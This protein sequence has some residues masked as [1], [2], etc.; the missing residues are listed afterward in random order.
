MKRETGSTPPVLLLLLPLLL[1]LPPGCGSGDGGDARTTGGCPPVPGNTAAE[2][3]EWAGLEAGRA[4][5]STATTYFRSAAEKL[6]DGD[7][8]NDGAAAPGDLQR[9]EYGEVLCLATVPLGIVDEFLSGLLQPPAGGEAGALA[10]RLLRGGVPFLHGLAARSLPPPPGRGAATAGDAVPVSL[11]TDYM[12]EMILPPIDRS[13]ERLEDV[14]SSPSFACELPVM[15]LDFLGAS[16]R[17]PAASPTGTGEHDLGEAYL[18]KA[19]L[20]F[21]RFLCRTVLST[22]L[23]LDAERIDDILDLILGGDPRELIELLDRYPSLLTVNTLQDSGV[24]GR[25]ALRQAKADLI[26]AVELLFDDDD[27][28]GRYWLDHRGTPLDPADDR[29]DPDERPD[30]FFDAVAC[31][32]DG[33]GDDIVRWLDRSTRYALGINAAA[34]GEPLESPLAGLAIRALFGALDAGVMDPVTRALYGTWPP[35]PDAA[36]GSPNGVDDDGD[37]EPDDGPA[38]AT[39]L[40]ALLAGGDTPL[41]QGARVGLLLNAL[42]DNPVDTRDLLPVWDLGAGDPDRLWF[43]VD[44]TESFEDTNGNGRYDPGTDALHD[45]PHRYGPYHF[46]PDGEYEP[47][48][49][50]FRHPTFAGAL[51]FGGSLAGADPHDSANRVLGAVLDRLL[52]SLTRAGA[53]EAGAARGSGPGAAAACVPREP[54]FPRSS[55]PEHLTVLD[56]YD[57]PADMRLTL[58]TLQGVVNRTAPRIY[59]LLSALDHDPAFDHEEDWLAHMQAAYGVTAGTAASPGELLDRFGGELAGVVVYDPAL[60]GSV[61]VA[62][63]LAGLERAAVIHPDRIPEMAARG[64]PVLRDLRGRWTDR[65]SLYRWAFRELWPRCNPRVLAFVDEGLPALRDYLVANDIFTVNL[66]YHIPEERALLEEILDATPRNIPVL[67]WAIDELIGVATFSAHGK[68]HVACDHVP[69]L[70][71]HSGLPARAYAQ[72]RPAGLPPLENKI[73][74]SYVYTDGD[75]L[76]YTSRWGRTIWDDPARG[77]IPLAYET[78][79]CLMDMSPDVLDYYFTTLTENDL[80]VSPVSGIGYIYP[81]LYPDLNRFLELTAPC[82]RDLDLDIQWILNQDMTFPDEILNR[83]DDHLHPLGF[84]LDYWDTSDLGFAYTSRG[85]P[86]LRSQYVYLLGGPEQVDAV[87]REKKAVKPFLSPDRPLFVMIGVNGWKVTPT[88]LRDLSA[89]LGDDFRVVRVD[90]MLRL[91]QRTRDNPCPGV[92]GGAD[93]DGDSWG[94]ACDNCPGLA[95]HGQEN[96]DGDGAGD[97]CDPDDDNDGVPDEADN[98]PVTANPDQEDRDGDGLGDRCDATLWGACAPPPAHAAATSA[99]ADPGSG[100]PVGWLLPLLG[101]P[102]LRRR[103]LARVRVLRRAG[104]GAG[105]RRKGA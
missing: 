100:V 49:F 15:R 63:V 29:V 86:T 74:V 39:A 82:C 101:V 18:L 23:N 7:P 60:P 43:V 24:D 54:V 48:Y 83:Y 88:Y 105:T 6:R 27:G 77:E 8:C 62:T 61:N 91:L 19:L 103:L 97:R 50:Y 22:N 10:L 53:A 64:L 99:G 51:H 25:E 90:T 55:F 56:A 67:G 1:G 96:Q 94:D 70:S 36:G 31:E 102:A 104:S 14:V 76:S 95:N 57:E 11:I 37:G 66:N 34:D 26:Q 93:T 78:A 71:V 72:P 30:D 87:L 92:E 35:E 21:A 69:N 2:D 44:R 89:G 81:N 79:L 4:N 98:C 13:V 38:D 45:A 73:Y 47:V 58:A 40:F 33:Q 9:A 42:F 75:S 68:F 5:Y 12:K 65:V 80:F 3:L 20:H 59:L 84:L 16:F 32:T 46:P 41:P 17:L 28:D 52:A 85:V